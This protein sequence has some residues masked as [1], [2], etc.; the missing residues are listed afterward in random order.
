MR[1]CGIGADRSISGNVETHAGAPSGAV[2]STHVFDSMGTTVSLDWHEHGTHSGADAAV[3]LPAAH[4]NAPIRLL[5]PD[6]AHT[7]DARRLG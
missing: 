5:L 6:S 7:R 2:I 4:G 3:R 1:A